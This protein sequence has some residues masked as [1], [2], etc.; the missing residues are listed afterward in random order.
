MKEG[1]YWQGNEE[2]DSI[3]QMRRVIVEGEEAGKQFLGRLSE[4]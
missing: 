1:E 2:V 4:S 3:A